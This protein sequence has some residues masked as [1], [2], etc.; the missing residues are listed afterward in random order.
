MT[1]PMMKEATLWD[2]FAANALAGITGN[3]ASGC[4]SPRDLAHW[5]A[6]VADS[7]ILERERRAKATPAAE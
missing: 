4:N 3:E 5:A 6:S 7:M 2:Y 1:K